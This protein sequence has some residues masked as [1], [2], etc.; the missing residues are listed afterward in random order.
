[1]APA[2]DRLYQAV[3]T[4]AVS[5]DGDPRLAAH[6]G[7]CVAKPTPM[8]DLVSKDKKGSPR[9][10]DAAVAAIVAFDRVAFNSNRPRQSSAAFAF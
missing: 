4:G 1:M 10:I 9:K 5:H 7:N 2:T 3:V 8:G 6:I